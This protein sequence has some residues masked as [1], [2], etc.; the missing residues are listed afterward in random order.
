V[1]GRAGINVVEYMSY[2]QRPQ[3]TVDLVI[4][5]RPR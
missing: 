2:E 3:A 5:Q 1:L 4:G